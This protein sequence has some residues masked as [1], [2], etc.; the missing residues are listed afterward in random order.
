M[1]EAAPRYPSKCST[2]GPRIICISTLVLGSG[3]NWTGWSRSDSTTD[4]RVSLA[5]EESCNELISV[6]WDAKSKHRLVEPLPLLPAAST[7][8]FLSRSNPH[9]KAIRAA[10]L[11]ASGLG[12]KPVIV[13]THLGGRKATGNIWSTRFVET[14]RS[15]R[16]LHAVDCVLW[17]SLNTA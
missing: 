14:A 11:G 15:R 7:W 16:T 5:V 17:F 6:S 12:G 3:A 1:K 2:G 4:R 9:S 10:S 8:Q 13:D